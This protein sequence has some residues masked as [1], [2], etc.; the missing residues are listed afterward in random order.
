MRVILKLGEDVKNVV[1]NKMLAQKLLIFH[2]EWG[3]CDDFTV[4]DITVP[5][6]IK[7]PNIPPLS[8]L[9]SRTSPLVQ[10]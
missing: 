7:Q 2:N 5:M 8:R 4:A 3:T 10:A 1:G 9:C 6:Q